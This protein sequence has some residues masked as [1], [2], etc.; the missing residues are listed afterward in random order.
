MS[1]PVYGLDLNGVHDRWASLNSDLQMSFSEGSGTVPAVIV[2]P[3]RRAEEPLAGNEAL[4]SIEGRGWQ[5]PK[6]ALG[7]DP[8]ERC[9]RVPLIKVL[10]KM[11]RG[12]RDIEVSKGESLPISKLLGTHLRHLIPKSASV[13]IAIP[14]CADETFQQRVL[15]SRYDDSGLGKISLLW[16]PVA[17]L[18]A[19]AQDL[20]QDE[21]LTIHNSKALVMYLDASGLQAS[22]LSLEVEKTD[23]GLLLTPVRSR[24]GIGYLEQYKVYE[25][26]QEIARH[27]TE[28]IHGNGLEW[29]MLWGGGLIWSGLLGLRSKAELLQDTNGSWLM[30]DAVSHL[31]SPEA[32]G[33]F[34]T[35]FEE[36]LDEL[37]QTELMQVQRVLVGGPF[38]RIS[39]VGHQDIVALIIKAAKKRLATLRTPSWTILGDSN[40]N[41]RTTSASARGAAIYGWRLARGLPTY[42][43]FLPQ[44]EISAEVKDKPKFVDLIPNTAKRI[45]GGTEFRHDVE[46]RFIIRRG[47]TQLD[48]YI[49]KEGEGVKSTVTRLK[50]PPAKAIEVSLFVRQTPGQGHAVV[51]IHPEQKGVFGSRDL[52]LDW[53]SLALTG[54]DKDQILDELIR[55]AGICY[56]NH[57]PVET[58]WRLWDN[59]QLIEALNKYL[60]TPLEF[61]LGK[62]DYTACLNELYDCLKITR[63]AASLHLKQGNAVFSPISSNGKLPDHIQGDI[64]T[65]DSQINSSSPTSLFQAALRRIAEDFGILMSQE[66]VFRIRDEWRRRLF[67]CAAWCYSSAPKTI[68]SYLSEEIKLGGSLGTVQAASRCFSEKK[69]VESFFA[70]AGSQYRQRSHN[71]NW[72][73]GL[74]Q[75]LRFREH[76]AEWLTDSQAEDFTSMALEVIAEEASA[77]RFKIKFLWGILLLMLLFRYRLRRR[78]F[79]K[80]DNQYYSQLNGLVKH[81]LSE[82]LEASK[83]HRKTSHFIRETL[84]MLDYKGT[85]QLVAG[86]LVSEMLEGKSSKDSGK[87]DPVGPKGA[88]TQQWT[89][90]AELKSLSRPLNLE[91]A[92]DEPLSIEP[93]APSNNKWEASKKLR[94]KRPFIAPLVEIETG[95]KTETET[96]PAVPNTVST[97]EFK[98]EKRRYSSVSLSDIETYVEELL[99]KSKFTNFELQGLIHEKFGYVDQLDSLIDAIRK[100]V[101]AGNAANKGPVKPKTS[102]TSHASPVDEPR[103]VPDHHHK[104]EVLNFVENLLREADV[105]LVEAKRLLNEKFGSS[106]YLSYPQIAIIKTRIHAEQ[107]EKSPRNGS[108]DLD[109]E[110]T[111]APTSTERKGTRTTKDA[112]D[113]EKLSRLVLKVISEAGAEVELNE[114]YPKL[115]SLLG[116]SERAYKPPYRSDSLPNSIPQVALSLLH[117]ASLTR[118]RFGCWQF[119]AA[120]TKAFNEV[121][122]RVEADNS[123]SQTSNRVGKSGKQN[124]N[125]VEKMSELLLK[126]IKESGGEAQL[127][128]LYPR[129]H[130][131]LGLIPAGAKPTHESKTI[132]NSIQSTALFLF[133]RGL[134]ARSRPSYWK[135][136]EAGLRAVAGPGSPVLSDPE[137][138]DWTDP[139]LVLIH[140][141]G[142]DRVK[143]FMDEL[144]EQL[145]DYIEEY[146]SELPQAESIHFPSEF[147]QQ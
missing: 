25:F 24:P 69:S 114:L 79:L 54:K 102:S 95:T 80:S 122:N 99:G 92:E 88:A 81:V 48:F 61:Q 12:A 121:L 130:D 28:R 132:A 49:H 89:S 119:T 15:E 112:L 76:A 124:I 38:L 14:D 141:Q 21:L 40:T 143:I 83:D 26:A 55:K 27:H 64:W 11:T 10:E 77:N 78:D 106:H 100:Q 5:W 127:Y 62:T 3:E 111:T 56:P 58:H 45:L 73:K 137:K 70:C 94:E 133:H 60:E 108:K 136:T 31:A 59:G 17:M 4:C 6:E 90:K 8:E 118:P 7:P 16:R 105:P 93:E 82:A 135:I 131:L 116:L 41:G 126:C 19:W 51:E 30:M 23:S 138:N 123:L 36:V 57:A 139:I 37:D 91:S 96:D 86:D 72:V 74:A 146:F 134:L 33:E 87:D 13:F 84:Q 34:F 42:Y 101:E 67:L 46:Q 68:V 142:E 1:E 144:L 115:A 22:I 145:P 147:T 75:V 63:T 85:N 29:Q 107:S 113:L 98:P 128:D 18:L 66:H 39:C 50:E 53:E 97:S 47:V 35:A 43:D 125:A 140:E 20:P 52:N 9:R 71:L 129:I 110:E 2:V 44:L 117:R 103:L 109:K 120:S 65:F 32:Q 104:K